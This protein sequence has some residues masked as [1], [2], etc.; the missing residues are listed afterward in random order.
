MS[1]QHMN[2]ETYTKV[3]RLTDGDNGPVTG[4]SLDL[5]VQCAD[6]KQAFQFVGVPGGYS[7]AQPMSNFDATELR[8]PIIPSQD[9]AEQIKPYLK[10][11]PN[12]P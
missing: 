12:T 11:H 9:P 5:R 2:F 1:C 6:C 8:I 3:A 4:Y 7:P 10:N